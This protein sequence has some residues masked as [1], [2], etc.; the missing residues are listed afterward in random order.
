MIFMKRAI[1]IILIFIVSVVSIACSDQVKNSDPE[2]NTGQAISPEDITKYNDMLTDDPNLIVLD[3]NT[4]YYWTIGGSKLH[5][6]IDCQSLTKSDS[7]DIQSGTLGVAYANEKTEPCS[8]CLKRAGIDADDFPTFDPSEVPTDTVFTTDEV[9]VIIDETTVLYWTLS[10]SKI[11]IFLTCQS[12]SRA[13]PENIKNGTIVDAYY[14]EKTGPCS[15]CLKKAGLEEGEF[16]VFIPDETSEPNDTTAVPDDTENDDPKVTV[17][18]TTILY[19]TKSGGKLHIF[20]TCQSLSRA[21]PDNIKSGTLSV[22]Y[23][24]EKTLPCSF[25][26]KKAGLEESDFPIFIP[27]ETD[28]SDDTE[29]PS[30]TTEKPKFIFTETTLY[31][32]TKGGTK[33]HIYPDCSSLSNSKELC[34]GSLKD[35]Y[36]AEKTNPC[37]FCLK[38]GNTEEYEFPVYVP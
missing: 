9:K 19:W 34:F 14:D 31:Y 6:F 10:G 35:A 5:I 29:Q 38:R 36:L 24:E 4:V 12:L 21:D 15:F 32:W 28:G 33:L 8:F 7:S 17:D 37:A 18:E 16:P 25:C 23:Y 26:L 2:R 27:T 30:E 3:E 22:A 13:D 1:F 20:L 11:H